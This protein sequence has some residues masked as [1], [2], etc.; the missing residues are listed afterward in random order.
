MVE[1]LVRALPPRQVQAL[2]RPRRAEHPHPHRAGELDRGEAHPAAGPVDQDGL[3]GAGMGVLA[4][5]GE[6]RPV[7]DPQAGPLGE[8]GDPQQQVHLGFEGEGIFRVGAADRLRRVDPVAGRHLGDPLADRLHL[9]GGVGARRVGQGRLDGVGA[10][11]HVGVVGVHPRR[12]DPDQDLPGAGAG[13]RHYMQFQ[14][15]RAS[16]RVD[17]DGFHGFPPQNRPIRR[18]SDF[19]KDSPDTGPGSAG[20][21]RAGNAHNQKF[22]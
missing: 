21:P 9:P 6:G 1:D 18:G 19:N 2:R 3:P 12:A 7:R 14:D 13:S 8:R 20:L 16:E 4:Q 11:A 5:G 17:L 10:V 15:F 22:E